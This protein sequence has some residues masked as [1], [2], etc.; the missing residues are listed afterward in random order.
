MDGLKLSPSNIVAATVSNDIKKKSGVVYVN[1]TLRGPPTRE[2]YLMPGEYEV[3]NGTGAV[4]IQNISRETLYFKEGFLVTC[5]LRID[6]DLNIN[7]ID[8]RDANNSKFLNYDEHLSTNEVGQ[9]K[10]K[11]QKF[12]HCF[13]HNLM[14]LG[15]T[16]V[17]KMEIE[18]NDTRPVAYYSRK[19]QQMSKSYILL[20][21]RHW[22]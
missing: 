14:D 19:K 5:A 10:E 3:K 1:S 16:H 13:S 15:Y 7:F 18:L 12:A 9:L 20:I 21:Y 4:L 17:D 6:E 11:L 8:L 22:L 2:Y